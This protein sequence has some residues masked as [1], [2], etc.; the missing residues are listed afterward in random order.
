[1][2]RRPIETTPVTGNLGGPR[3]TLTLVEG[4]ID[5]CLVTSHIGGSQPDQWGEVDPSTLS[6]VRRLCNGPAFIEASLS[7]QLTPTLE[8]RYAGTCRTISQPRQ[9]FVLSRNFGANRLRFLRG[10]LRS[11]RYSPSTERQ[12]SWAWESTRHAEVP[13]WRS[14]EHVGEG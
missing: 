12:E 10:L 14:K 13:I 2:L 8:G 9:L 6:S 5:C 1:M 3:A 7:G 4:E 11:R